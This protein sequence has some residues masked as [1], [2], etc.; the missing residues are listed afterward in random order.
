MVFLGAPFLPTH[1]S[2]NA[3][4]SVSGGISNFDRFVS[5]QSSTAAIPKRSYSDDRNGCKCFGTNPQP[6]L[7]PLFNYT[8][9][10]IATQLNT[11]NNCSLQAGGIVLPTFVGHDEIWCGGQGVAVDPSTTVTFSGLTAL[12]VVS[13]SINDLTVFSSPCSFQGTFNSSPVVY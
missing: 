6:L 4:H 5:L 11:L 10:P 12:L 8:I 9:L 1:I 3:N 13:Y 7:T 2:Y